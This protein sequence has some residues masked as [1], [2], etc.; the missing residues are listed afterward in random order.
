MKKIV[1]VGGGFGGLYTALKLKDLDWSDS[2]PEIILIEQNDRF[3][4]S[5]L[6]Y[7]L[8]TEE[9]QSWE[10]AP[11]YVDLLA[12]TPIRFIQD[13]VV[14]IDNTTQ[15]VVLENHDNVSYDRLVVALGG[16]TPVE[17]VEGAKEYAI[18]FRTLDHAYRLKEKLRNLEYLDQEII[19]VAVVGGGYS[20]VELA[21]KIADRLGERGRMRIID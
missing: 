15:E 14:D 10:V 7:E 8:V 5:P 4:F 3:V 12:N 9:M 20:G 11:Y 2:I 18:P 13:K 17:I 1:I 19:R 21:L 6:L 16:K